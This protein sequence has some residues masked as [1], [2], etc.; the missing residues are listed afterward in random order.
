MT[1]N[2]WPDHVLADISLDAYFGR[3]NALGQLLASKGGLQRGEVTAAL[4]SADPRTKENAAA[5]LRSELSKLR[6]AQSKVATLFA[7]AKRYQSRLLTAR[8]AKC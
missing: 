6:S 4:S 2:G 7:E 8:A 3:K 1:L 5:W